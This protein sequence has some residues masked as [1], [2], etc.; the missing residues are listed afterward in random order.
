MQGQEP[1]LQGG[2]P[3]HQDVHR[4]PATRLHVVTDFAHIQRRGPFHQDGVRAEIGEVLCHHIAELQENHPD[5]A[6]LA[7]LQEFCETAG[8]LLT[9]EGSDQDPERIAAALEEFRDKKK[10]LTAKWSET[11]LWEGSA[12]ISH[13]PLRDTAAQAALGNAP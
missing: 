10:A 8:Q 4:I 6:R 11:F 9:A 1:V 7:D 3:V 2:D 5:Y 12:E 13:A